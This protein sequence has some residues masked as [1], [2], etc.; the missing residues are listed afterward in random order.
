MLKEK[1]KKVL[2]N[3]KGFVVTVETIAWIAVV[4]VMLV[5]VFAAVKPKITGTDGVLDKSIDRIVD[6]EN[7]LN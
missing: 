1:I 4:S 2:K 7:A 5:L 6:V 3:E